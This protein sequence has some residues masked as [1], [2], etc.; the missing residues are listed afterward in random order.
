MKK[1]YEE[2]ERSGA[3]AT[4][5]TGAD[6]GVTTND[7]AYFAT[8]AEAVEAAQAGD[9]VILLKDVTNVAQQLIACVTWG[10]AGGAGVMIGELLG[11]GKLDEAKKYGDRFYKVSFL[12]G[13]INALLIAITGPLVYIFYTLTDVAKAI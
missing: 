12:S 13:L 10:I 4:V 9:T 2:H 7:V 5:F 1:L 11:A 3:K 8:L 6:N